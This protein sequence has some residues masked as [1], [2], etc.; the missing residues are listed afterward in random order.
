MSTDTASRFRL[1]Y[2][3]ETQE[4]VESEAATMART[5]QAAQHLEL[6]TPAQVH[7]TDNHD[8][9]AVAV[10]GGFCAGKST[11]LAMM[12]TT[13]RGLNFD[14]I[15]VPENHTIVWCRTLCCFYM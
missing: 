5:E 4:K 9:A 10:S 13:L 11:V 8:V 12:A 15:V 7:T 1:I 3:L 14:V 6:Y 2:P